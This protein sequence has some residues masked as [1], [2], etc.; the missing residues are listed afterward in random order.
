MLADRP[1]KEF[2]KVGRCNDC[3]HIRCRQGILTMN[4]DK[5]TDVQEGL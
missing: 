5:P 4:I 3:L 1:G 2:E